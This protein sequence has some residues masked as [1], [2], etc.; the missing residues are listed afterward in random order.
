MIQYNFDEIIN[1]HGS[2]AVKTD[3][4]QEHFGRTDLI[5]MWVADMDFRTGDF[6]T[7]ALRKCCDHGV[8]GYPTLSEDYFQTIRCW[9]KNKHRW[10]IEEEWINF[11][12]GIVKGIAFC[13]INFTQPGDKIIIQPPVYHPFRI[14]PEMNQRQIIHNPLIEKNGQFQMD[15]DGLRNILDQ[16]DCKLLILCNPHNPI[17]ITWTKETLIELA[18]ICYE[19]DVLI[20]SDEI[21]SDMAI[22]GHTHIPF[23][24]VSEKAFNNSITFMAPSKTFNMA[25]I[26][27][28]YSI[29]P[30]EKIRTNFFNFLQGGELNHG[31]LF[32]YAATKA[33]YTHGSEWLKQ[34]LKYI[35]DNILF[36][37]KYL[38]ENIPLI[39][40][41]IP[42]ASF[43]VW[44][45]CRELGF[46]QEKLVSLFIDKAGLALNDGEMFGKEGCGFMRMNVGC[47]RATIEKALD[48]LKKAMET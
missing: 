17:G 38:Q 19:K 37:S 8:F 30:N 26:V 22:F 34:M 40:A 11:I 15:L 42:Q 4:L 21:H 6:I 31:N 9:I 32:A 46:S 13:V 1:R 35:E 43:L 20:V 48:Q 44:L 25:G 5:P 16:E 3:A 23:A 10:E 27:S 39:K 28:S 33:A 7:Q 2:G 14:V 41:I 18:E 29:V 36:T 24:S 47:P 45:D 12:P